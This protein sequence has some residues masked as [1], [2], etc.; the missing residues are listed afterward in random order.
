[1]LGYFLSQHKEINGPNKHQSPAEKNSM[2]TIIMNSLQKRKGFSIIGQRGIEFSSS[3]FSKPGFNS[4]ATITNGKLRR[5]HNST[6]H[7]IDGYWKSFIPMENFSRTVTDRRPLVAVVSI[8]Q[9]TKE[10]HGQYNKVRNLHGNHCS[11]VGHE[12]S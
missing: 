8:D 11:W 9:R 10:S 4:G 3:R 2:I 12:N 7:R 1:M 5:V 6:H